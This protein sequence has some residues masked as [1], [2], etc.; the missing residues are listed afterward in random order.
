MVV[1]FS[2]RFGS[3]DGGYSPLSGFAVSRRQGSGARGVLSSA[4]PAS[5][6]K[7]EAF[8]APP[9]SGFGA[10][11]LAVES[12]DDEDG[13]CGGG[14]GVCGVLSGKLPQ[15]GS[16]GEDRSTR[17]TR[18]EDGDTCLGLRVGVSSRVGL[19]LMEKR[20]I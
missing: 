5:P 8:S 2:V 15:I 6:W 17:V 1:S 20:N 14:A 4:P 3:G 13:C 18:E 10:L 7:L 16:R 19:E 12:V 9:L 11:G